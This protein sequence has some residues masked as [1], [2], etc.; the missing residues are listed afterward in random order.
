MTLKGDSEVKGKLTLGLK[1][2]I[3]NLLNFHV[4]SRKS[5]SLHPDRLALCKAN[6]DINAKVQKS[7][8]T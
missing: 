6:K 3:G 1:N 7:H 5:E 4:S 2:G 8:D